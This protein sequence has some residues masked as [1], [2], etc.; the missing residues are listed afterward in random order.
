[1]LGLPYPRVPPTA[2]Q[3]GSSKRPCAVC[4]I[5][6]HV[7]RLETNAIWLAVGVRFE[8]FRRKSH[9][10]H[11][12]IFGQRPRSGHSRPVRAAPRGPAAHGYEMSGRNLAP[13]ESGPLATSAAAAGRAHPD[14]DQGS[15]LGR[16]TGTVPSHR[17]RTIAPG[18]YVGGF[19]PGPA[20]QAVY[21]LAPPPPVLSRRRDRRETIPRTGPREHGN[22]A[23]HRRTAAPPLEESNIRRAQ[24]T[25]GAAEPIGPGSH[26][27]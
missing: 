7:R 16:V 22:S 20:W 9:S 27:A 24:Q 17:R 13:P 5:A 12:G 11:P 6:R 4:A 19:A 3:R 21:V 18:P 10:L 1:M 25:L 8:E 26:Q 14:G 2:P 15:D 23:D